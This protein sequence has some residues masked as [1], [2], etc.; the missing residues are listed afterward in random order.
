MEIAIAQQDRQLPQ[1]AVHSRRLNCSP[2][3]ISL[4]DRKPFCGILISQAY[5]RFLLRIDCT[6]LQLF[7]SLCALP[8]YQTQEK[9]NLLSI[10]QRP[11]LAKTFQKFETRSFSTQSWFRLR[12]FESSS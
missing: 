11:P 12:R 8:T 10:D 1:I 3:M 9:Q 7:C 4:P 2:L 6:H 5:C